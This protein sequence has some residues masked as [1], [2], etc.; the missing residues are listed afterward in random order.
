MPFSRSILDLTNE[1]TATAGIEELPAI[2]GTAAIPAPKDQTVRR[3]KGCINDA[4]N[5]LNRSFVWPTMWRTAEITVPAG[6]DGV[7]IP[8]DMDRIRSETFFQKNNP[9]W[10][11]HGSQ[12]AA[13]WRSMKALP[14]DPIA[15][16]W[17]LGA[18]RIL[19]HPVPSED[20]VFM[21]EYV[22]GWY[23]VDTDDRFHPMITSDDYRTVFDDHILKL[24]LKWRVL[25]EF[26]EAYGVELTEANEAINARMA[27]ENA[28]S[29][30]RYGRGS[31][32]DIVGHFESNT[33]V[34]G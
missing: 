31:V 7:P 16:R 2:Y 22:S 1:A 12:S 19:F 27:Q 23:C 25:R 14:H 10:S 33:V 34:I 6:Y 28:P 24:E 17:R 20:E 15:N 5:N 4:C 21:F 11:S 13:S 8:P 32:D 18:D 9:F 29:P 3:L 26:G 30:I